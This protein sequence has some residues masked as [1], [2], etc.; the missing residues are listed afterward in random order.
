MVLSNILYRSYHANFI[1]CTVVENSIWVLNGL[2]PQ[3]TLRILLCNYYQ[4]SNDSKVLIH[5]AALPTPLFSFSNI[6]PHDWICQNTTLFMYQVLCTRFWFVPGF[7]LPGFLSFFKKYQ[8]SKYQVFQKSTSFKV[9]GRQKYQVKS[10]RT[11]YFFVQ[12]G[13][14]KT[15]DCIS[16]S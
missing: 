12:P 4:C 6:R 2:N 13:K 1:Y 14:K 5:H 8:V 16:K 3:E 15:Y 11:W 9:P 10:T 7:L